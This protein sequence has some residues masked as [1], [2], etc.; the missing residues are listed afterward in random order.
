MYV[1]AAKVGFYYEYRNSCS[2]FDKKVGIVK[3]RGQ[4]WSK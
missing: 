1:I 4:I 2:S 3:L